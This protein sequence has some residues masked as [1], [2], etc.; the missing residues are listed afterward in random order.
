MACPPPQPDW[1][2]IAMALFFGA[3]VGLAG[4]TFLPR[5]EPPPE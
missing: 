5:D 3:M 1:G 4:G 2:L